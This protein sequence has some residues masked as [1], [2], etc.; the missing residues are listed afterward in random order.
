MDT[1]LLLQSGDGG[2]DI[3]ATKI[4]IGS[5]RFYDQVKAYKPGHIVT[6]DEVRSVYGR[7]SKPWG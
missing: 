7:A 5:I 6:A 4:G 1:S 3:I 2:R